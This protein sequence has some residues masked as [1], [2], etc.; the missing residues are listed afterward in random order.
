M[1][2]HEAIS[3]KRRDV[4]NVK[5]R[6][7]RRQP[8]VW[9]E[10]CWPAGDVTTQNPCQARTSTCYGEPVQCERC[11]AGLCDHH[12]QLHSR[13]A[14]L[15]PDAWTRCATKMVAQL[16]DRTLPYIARTPEANAPAPWV[17][18]QHCKTPRTG[19]INA[20]CGHQAATCKGNPQECPR[21]RFP[22]CERHLPR[23]IRGL[24]WPKMQWEGIVYEFQAKMAWVAVR[25][26]GN[27]RIRQATVRL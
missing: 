17:W 8:P 13:G 22:Y 25:G 23:H 11:G 14:A 6:R 12:L 3:R 26:K 1:G 5:G 27:V 4:L 16:R 20:V 10:Y 19:K 18:I 2:R 7:I 15:P 9:L 21:C 24:W